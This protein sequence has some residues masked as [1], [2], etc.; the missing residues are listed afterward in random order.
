MK[1]ASREH[2]LWQINEYAHPCGFCG[3]Y[4]IYYCYVCSCI[5]TAFGS[6]RKLQTCSVVHQQV[7]TLPC[8]CPCSCRSIAALFWLTLSL[9]LLQIFLSFF[10]LLFSTLAFPQFFYRTLLVWNMWL[11]FTTDQLEHSEKDGWWAGYTCVC[12]CVR[13]GLARHVCLFPTYESQ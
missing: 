4:Q 1:P 3:L 5:I 13:Q 7:A 9:L 11:P 10:T 2:E 6:F 12:L 8:L